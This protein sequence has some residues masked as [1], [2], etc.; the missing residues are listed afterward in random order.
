MINKS[1]FKNTIL[2]VEKKKYKNNYSLKK[3]TS[4]SDKVIVVTASQKQN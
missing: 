2:S 3:Y 1:A 4:V